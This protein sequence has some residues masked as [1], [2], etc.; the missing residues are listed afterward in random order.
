MPYLKCNYVA[1]GTVE[2]RY[3]ATRL[4]GLRS[5]TQLSRISKKCRMQR[6]WGAGRRDNRVP[7]KT[8]IRCRMRR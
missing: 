3:R 4:V 5:G 7:E 1:L 6:F 8:I 2:G